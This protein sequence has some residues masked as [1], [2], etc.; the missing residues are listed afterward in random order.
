MVIA[1]FFHLLFCFCYSPNNVCSPSKFIKHLLLG[2]TGLGFRNMM[3]SKT[4][5]PW[6]YEDCSLLVETNINPIIPLLCNTNFMCTE[7]K[8]QGAKNCRKGLELEC[9]FRERRECCGETICD[10][11]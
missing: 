6:P 9:R 4:G 1:R 5:P 2:S 11:S 10:Q 7:E 3:I 8:V